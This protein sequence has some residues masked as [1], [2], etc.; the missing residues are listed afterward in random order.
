MA[1]LAPSPV[2]EPE[3]APA[4]SPLFSHEQ[5]ES[6]ALRLA[7]AHIVSPDPRRARPLLPRLDASAARLAE[8][9]QFL[10]ADALSDL[11]AVA[12]EDWL[13]DNYYVVQ[14]QVREVRQDLPRRFYLQLPKLADGPHAGYPRV[15]LIARELIA[16]TAGRLDLEMLVDFTAA[17]Q[18]GSPL[19]IGE[20]WAIPIML[21]L[22]LVE[23]LQ[24]L[25]DGVVAARRSRQQART[26]E[27]AL[28]APGD[29]R[30]DDLAQ[31]LRAEVE[32]NG[33]LSSAFV[34]ELMQWLRDQPQSAAGA[35]QALQRALEAQR[36]SPEVL[37]RLEHQREATDQL[38]IS[39]IITSMRLLSS[40]DWRLFFDRVSVVEEILARDAAGAYAEM[41]FETRDRYRHSIEE[42]SRRSRTPELVVAE[43]AITLA[44]EAMERD[45]ESDRRHHVGYYLISRGR[46]TLEKLL[47]YQPGK[48][49]RLARFFFEHPALGYPATIGLGM[50]LGVAGLLAYGHRHG[51]S[52]GWLW[53][54][55]LIVLLPVSE[56]AIALLNAL[57][58]AVIQPRQLPKLALKKGI[59]AQARTVV[60]VPAII[61]S[62]S[63]V[64]GL[65]HDLEVR[66][67]ANRDPHLHFA[68][69]S[70]LPD[71]A[72]PTTAGDEALV[73]LARAKV[74]ALNERH[75]RDRFLLCHRER[76][77]NESQRQWMGWERKRGKLA[78]FNRLLR[79][80]RDTSFVVLHGDL[81]VL[82]SIKYV[83]TL[84]SDTHLPMDAAR[85]LV[86]ALSHPLNRPRFN[87]HLRR[88]T[89]GYGILQPRVQV[90]V[91]SAARTAFAQVYSGHVGLDPYT[92]A[93]SDVYQDLFHEGT[94][95]GKGIYDVDAFEAALAGRVPENALL[96]HDLFEGLYARAGL[97]TDIDVVDDYPSNY[98]AFASRQHRWVRGDWQILRWLWRTVPD[99]SGRAVPNTL[100]AIA[101]WKILDN[102]RRSLLAPA[103]IVLL[104]A[105]WTVLP[106]SA[107]VWSG[108]ALM[109][110]AFPAYMQVGRSLTSRARGVPLREHILAERDNVAASATQAFLATVFLLHQCGVMIDAIVRTLVRLIT[111]R[112]MLEWITADR[113]PRAV[114]TLRD[115]VRRMAPVPIAAGAIALLVGVVALPRL[116]VALPILLVWASSPLLAYATGRPMSSDEAH[117]SGAQRAAF[118]RTARKM[119][120]FFDEFVTS[121]DHW[122]IPDNIQENRR[123]LIAHRTS[124]TN[125]G[126]QL[127]SALAAY[128]FGYISLTGLL[129]RL[130]A[131]FAT[132]L[133]MQRYR[134]HFYNWYDTR[135]LEPLAPRYIS[136]VDSGNLAGCLV[137]VRAA[138]LEIA[139]RAPRTGTSV[140]EGLNDVVGLVEEELARAPGGKRGDRA[141]LRKE[142][143]L[144]RADLAE[145][146][147]APGDRSLPLAQIRDRLSAVAVLLHEI[148]EPLLAEGTESVATV[149]GDAG[150]W[151]DQAAAAVREHLRDVEHPLSQSDLTERVDH[152]AALADD[153]VEETEFDFLFDRERQLFSIGFNVV[154]GRLDASYY[155]TL[156]SEARLASF[157][158]IATGKVPPEHWFRL[159]RAL[160]S[161]GGSRALLSWSASMF[162]Y[163]MPLLVMRTYP[164]TLLHETYQAV[165]QRQIQYGEGRGVPWGISESAYNT[166]DLDG[167]Y[168]YRA[169]GVPGLG[170]KRGLGDDLVIAPYATFLAA[171]IAPEAVLDNLDRLRAVGLDAK[172]G[173]YEAIDYTP[174][175]LPEGH[176]GGMPLPTYMAH[177]Q[178]MSLVAIDNALHHSVMQQRFHA[179]PRVCAA[180]LLLQERIPRLV[181]LKHPPIERG[182]RVP[183]TR[184]P[185]ALVRRYVTPHTLSPRTHFLSNG[186]YVVMLTNAGGGFS[187][188]QALAMTRWREDLTADA[189]GTF[190]YLRDVSS[191]DVWSATYQPT[192]REPDDYEVT[193]AADRATFRRVDGQLETRTE[194]VVSPEDDVELRRVSITNHGTQPRTVE[195]TS[196]VEVVLAPHDADLAHPAFSNLFVETAAVPERDA[197]MCVR[198]PRSG[199][200]RLHLVHVLSGRSRVGDALEYE[201]DRARFI[202]RGRRTDRPA[203]LEQPLSKTTGAVLDPIV[204]LRHTVRIPPGGTARIGFAT[205]FADSDVGARQ[206]IEK[207]HDRRVVAREL[208]LASTHSDIELR[209]LGLTVEETMTFQR[210]SGR[211]MYGDPRLRPVEAVR[212]NLRSQ[213]DLWKYGISGDLAILLVHIKED[214]EAE[215]LHD[216]LKAHEYLRRKGL[217]FDLVVLNDHA[218][219]YLQDL[220][221]RLLQMVEGSPEQ[222]W[223]DRPGG[224][225]LR[226]SDLVPAADRMLLEAAARV[227]MDGADGNLRQQLKRPQ[228]PFGPEPGEIRERARPE[229]RSPADA[230]PAS[231]PADVELFNGI[232][233]FADDGREYAVVVDARTGTQ[234]PQPWANVVANPSFGF[235]ATES[236]SG[237]TWSRNSHDN[238]LTPWANDPVT[239][240]QGE[241]I[242][243]REEETGQFWSATPL[244]AGSGERYI[245]R[246]GQGY[247]TFDHERHQLQSTLVVFVPPVDE[248]KVFH[249][250]LRNQSTA[251]RRFTVTLY[252]EWVLGEN[253]SRS[254]LHVVTSQDA[255]TNAVFARNAFRQQ[256][257]QRVAFLD[258]HAGTGKTVTGDRTEFVGRNGRLSQ[259]AAMRR[260]SLSGRTGPTLDPCGAIQVSIDLGPSETQ[261]I[262]GLLGDA[263]DEAAAR[264]LVR[265]YRDTTAVNTAMQRVVD[266]WDRL[267]QTVVVK[268]PDRAFDLLVN[269]WL[270]HQC[271]ACRVWG[272]S[273]FYQSSGAFGFRDQL[274]DVLALLWSAPQIARAHL[275]H[276]ASRQFREGDVQ[277]WWH[278]PGGEGVRTRFSDDR[279]WLVYATLEYIAATG[280]HDVLDEPAPFLEG[281]RLEPG[282]HDAYERPSISVERA[283][284]YEHCARAVSIS[285]ATGS[286]GLPHIGTGDWNDGM[287]LVGAEGRGESVWLAWF[288]LS[289]LPPFTAL[290]EQRGDPRAA[291]WRA[292]VERLR[293]SAEGAWDGAWYRRAYFDDGTPLGSAENEECRIDA[294]AQSWAVLS[295]AANPARARQAM[296]SLDEHLVRREDG[297]VLLLTPPFDRM[298]PSPGY[299]RGYVPGVRENG[300]QYTH[301][302]L[303]S[304]LA[305]ARLGDGTRAME[306]FAMLNPVNKTRGIEDVA[307]YRAEPYVV[308][309]DVYSAAGHT[310]RGGWTWYTGAAGWMYRVGIE[311]LLG[312]S[313]RGGALHVEPCIPS[314]WPGYEAVIKTQQA[315]LRIT[316]E[317]PERVA[318][319]VRRIELDGA[320]VEGD[321]PLVDATGIHVVRV[322]LGRDA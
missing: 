271:L 172:Y 22:G 321:I 139:E 93:V 45:P 170:L 116:A 115:L 132:L 242:F 219:S 80:A 83:I 292:H 154:D 265:K 277:H 118:R 44:R 92:T 215:L 322:V 2:L 161:S 200:E 59:P 205:G 281:R 298:V 204:S 249:L 91:E 252:V 94:Y 263:D 283:S 128:D 203:A 282:E 50:A 55:G 267:L 37:V 160:T 71:A 30:A 236:G 79:G 275:L 127:L 255:D 193:F 216:L 177:H 155:D 109:V 188:R 133:T 131:T 96:S 4:P 224:V 194:V 171:P 223:I 261:T 114:P 197:I 220:Q 253:R 176:V 239:D 179:D 34:V 159:G 182:D 238:R 108:L 16:H 90:S 246:H 195:L 162:E 214:D 212:G 76:R 230:P 289:I 17:Y 146:V 268:T 95:V 86:G 274:Q 51:A 52:T 9:Y 142:L 248:A 234:P 98:L 43:H 232:G 24:R 158:A 56:L 251:R 278:E 184:R 68:L 303:W 39:N 210:L 290:A 104:V 295:A 135:T 82:R 262:V 288:Q 299:I 84:D 235:V 64:E 42:L 241:A 103:L 72:T 240:A 129:A 206:L 270:L 173:F 117:L 62:E 199:A 250:T 185:P 38:G 32:K 307:R 66:F 166:R 190:I 123:D 168:Q 102:L 58:T 136:T 254:H 60:V 88:V 217:L 231:P 10:S 311:G 297:L 153:L 54:V 41:D 302:A 40:I 202:G 320:A 138:L 31:R 156:S 35:W 225:F 125:I 286:H 85:R 120:R 294:I 226:R 106:G 266:F 243:I 169:F 75:G 107:M 149:V 269:R 280:D 207:Y 28:A 164:G 222:R 198:R 244:P 152:L 196:Y 61:D 259:P 89:E 57:L 181:P 313:L 228:I 69:L 46:F 296:E 1:D 148:E 19:S 147:A 317:N 227:V 78:E 306:L 237:Y 315:E 211:L 221:N 63:R 309:A 272:R 87:P 15:Y 23:E 12:S 14:D 310:G 74:D 273:A 29:L 3:S 21:R 48:R 180:E 293:T 186:S 312:L 112:Q 122:L 305:F 151:L 300:G 163:L 276:A 47:R 5:L 101:R 187:R 192:A 70:D 144:L 8:S 99:S 258:L 318:G 157:L 308:A 301:A 20:T 111:R 113:A 316:V 260:A 141:A 119:W 208:A 304:V 174:E 130:D 191:G 121:A 73:A 134:G 143:T 201:T 97:C 218:A 257:S 11:P 126:L 81:T 13:R 287:N 279:L 36:Q 26:W 264:A 33:P 105:G 314:S 319:G 140:I 77:W 150:Y 167:N 245:V 124:P 53:V 18:R 7:A 110:L 291:E 178:G 49:E 65:L 165:V 256:F 233:G 189:W 100:P 285:L 213:A 145:A 6:H 247:T 175:R 137:T 27:M 284:L 183:A 229:E 67:L 25:V 209:H